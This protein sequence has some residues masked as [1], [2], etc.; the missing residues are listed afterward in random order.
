MK[1]IK[2]EITEL[3]N[4]AELKAL[5]IK[6]ISPNLRD[7]SNNVRQ[8]LIFTMRVIERIDDEQEL[9]Q[10]LEEIKTVHYKLRL[11]NFAPDLENI[12]INELIRRN[13]K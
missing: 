4:D 1:S 11:V 13:S 6:D 7:I 2:Q 9:K 10:I 5:I 8:G 12:Y 3:V